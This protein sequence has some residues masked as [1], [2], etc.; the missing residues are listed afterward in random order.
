[1]SESPVGPALILDVGTARTKA[2]LFDVV[3]GVHRFVAQGVVPT[4]LHGSNDDVSVG[5]RKAIGQIEEI[6]GRKLIGP[7][8]P[9]FPQRRD[10]NG[11]DLLASTSSLGDQLRLV[12]LA[13]DPNSNLVTLVKAA[14]KVH[15]ADLDILPP[16]KVPPSERGKP[17]EDLAAAIGN[18]DLHALVIVGPDKSGPSTF[19]G[20]LAD[21]ISR[22]LKSSDSGRP[23]VLFV[24]K[25]ADASTASKTLKDR[26]DFRSVTVSGEVRDQDVVRRLGQELTKLWQ[27]RVIENVP[28]YSLVISWQNQHVLPSALSF[29]TSLSL[30]SHYYERSIIGVDVGASGVT[31]CKIRDGIKEMLVARSAG[32]AS[33]SLNDPQ[34]TAQRLLAV[35]VNE[36][37]LSSAIWNKCTRPC[38]IP[39]TAA[40]VHLEMAYAITALRQALNGFHNA[41][42]FSPEAKQG[43]L[44]GSGGVFAGT[45]R[46]PEMLMILLDGVEPSGMFEIAV[47]R[48]S[49]LPQLGVLAVLDS[50]AAAE[51]IANDRLTSLASC[52]ACDGLARRGSS[53]VK[54]D[55]KSPRAKGAPKLD[56]KLDVSF[57]SLRLVRPRELSVLETSS[58]EVPFID[59]SSN[60]MPLNKVSLNQAS[61]PNQVTSSPKQVTLKVAEDLD[62]GWGKGKGGK[63]S[64]QHGPFGLIIDARGRP[65]Q[66]PSSADQALAKRKEWLAALGASVPR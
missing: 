42:R 15:Y 50:Q 22:R 52:W 20:E 23:A 55:M 14:A 7:N 47:D 49:I 25:D 57:G 66:I 35:P 44:V 65:L 31:V 43:L 30:I 63:A 56:A 5:V 58:N 29:A 59:V 12:L 45:G 19:V 51:V 64:L 37:E 36:E 3:A 32:V 54:V 13:E 16:D 4:T 10:G 24:G 34:L 48:L 1:M 28:G 11:I 53:A 39:H 17:A 27:E 21:A 6:S 33:E 26:C 61:S 62:L 60:G 2:V 46:I 40:D 8:G 41:L 9:I 18:S 38:S